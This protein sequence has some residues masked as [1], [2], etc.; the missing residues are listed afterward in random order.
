[1]ANRLWLPLRGP[2]KKKYPWRMGTRPPDFSR[3]GFPFRLL[4]TGHGLKLTEE[5]LFKF[6][7]IMV[8]SACSMWTAGG[9]LGVSNVTLAKWKDHGEK[10]LA[11]VDK[12]ET[13]DP[14]M[15]MYGDFVMM[16]RQAEDWTSYDLGRQLRKKKYDLNCWRDMAVASRRARRDWAVKQEEDKSETPLQ[17]DEAYL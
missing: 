16:I 7:R 9:L 15:E 2:L 4:P 17:P 5:I 1:M 12:G 6:H 8:D 3:P 14:K 13:P 10:Y 11:Q